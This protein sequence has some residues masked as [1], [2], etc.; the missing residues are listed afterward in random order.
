MASV[1]E[2]YPAS[3]GIDNE[4]ELLDTTSSETTVYQRRNIQKV[5]RTGEN[6]ET[7]EEYEYEERKIPRET[8]FA[9]TLAAES[10]DNKRESEIIDEYTEQLLEEG[11]L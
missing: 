6:N 4:P 11:V 9:A 1:M 5:T 2:W 3:C 10:V 7:F 8:Y